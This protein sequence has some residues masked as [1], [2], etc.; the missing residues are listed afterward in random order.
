V[1]IEK[2]G[3]GVA[4]MYGKVIEAASRKHLNEFM[5]A[6]VNQYAAVRTDGWLGY[7]GIELVPGPCQ[8]EIGKEGN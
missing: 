1:A 8:S 3:R 5:T 2:K 6:S 4:R 7:S